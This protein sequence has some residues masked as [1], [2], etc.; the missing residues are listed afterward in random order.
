MINLSK[1][2]DEDFIYYLYA[3]SKFQEEKNHVGVFLILDGLYDKFTWD[4]RLEN[5]YML[6][7]LKIKEVQGVKDRKPAGEAIEEKLNFV[8]FKKRIGIK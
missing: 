4:N 1:V 6:T 7:Y 2:E 3:V 8:N 5:L